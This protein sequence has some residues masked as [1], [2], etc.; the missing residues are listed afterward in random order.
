MLTQIKVTKKKQRQTSNRKQVAMKLL[1]SNKTNNSE[2]DYGFDGDDSSSVF[3]YDDSENGDEN[4]DKCDCECGP[5]F[6]DF[7]EFIWT[8]STCG[9]VIV[10]QGIFKINKIE[11]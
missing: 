2:G 6:L 7:W 11:S 4:D 10:A 1:N 9:V 3:H 8:V 5:D